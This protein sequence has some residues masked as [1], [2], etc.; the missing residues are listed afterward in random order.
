MKKKSD[1]PEALQLFLT[2]QTATLGPRIP[3]EHL[4]IQSD[5]EAVLATPQVLDILAKA[6]ITKRNTGEPNQS[7]NGLV[8]R[9]QG[10]LKNTQLAIRHT[11]N[12][13]TSMAHLAYSHAATIHN[14]KVHSA[15]G[16]SPWQRATGAQP[17][18]H[19]LRTFG[20]KAYLHIDKKDRTSRNESA[21]LG[22]YV[23]LNINGH[24]YLILINNKLHTTSHVTFNEDEAG[25]HGLRP[26]PFDSINEMPPPQSPR[27]PSQTPQQWMHQQ[28]Y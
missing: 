20:C 18:L 24:G 23:G 26:Q 3:L 12:L 13:P 10:E 14:M 22:S 19:L 11:F 4:T 8:E 16:M 5:N 7:A 27:L 21:L 17:P 2:Q 6:G 15:L 1:V 9:V 28:T 25:P